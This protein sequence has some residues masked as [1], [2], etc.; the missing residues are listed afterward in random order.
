MVLSFVLTIL[1]VL[2]IDFH[3]S[4]KPCIPGI[5]AMWSYC[6]IILYVSQFDS[7]FR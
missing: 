7:V 1:Y 2:L 6:I 4:N 5:N 3:M